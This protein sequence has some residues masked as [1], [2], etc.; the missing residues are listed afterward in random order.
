MEDLKRKRI[1]ED[2][3]N[4]KTEEVKLFVKA[5]LF[6]NPKARWSLEEKDLFIKM[7]YKS[8]VFYKYLH[9]LGFTL[10]CKKTIRAWYSD[11]PFNIGISDYILNAIK[12]KTESMDPM[13][14]K[15]VLLIDEMSIKYEVEYDS[16]RDVIFGYE[17]LGEF[18][19]NQNR[20]KH[21]LVGRH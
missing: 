7:N 5:Q 2:Y 10:P 9:S 6:H 17:D 19:R 15:C 14:K 4:N 18:G 21:A 13:N 20:A 11:I 8:P 16:K 3:L 1:I 12:N